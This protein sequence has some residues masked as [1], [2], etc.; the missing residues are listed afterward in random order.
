MYRYIIYTLFLQQPG[1]ELFFF[2]IELFT[3]P[4]FTILFFPLNI[5]Y[6][7]YTYM[8]CI[9]MYKYIYRRNPANQLICSQ[10]IP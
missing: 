5:Y 3:H 10:F 4:E 1:S 7:K 8:I 2:F 9:N 6:L